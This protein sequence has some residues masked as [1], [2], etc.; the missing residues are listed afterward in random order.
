[1]NIPNNIFDEIIEYLTSRKTWLVLVHEK[2]DG[3]TL[4]SSAALVS[5]GIRLGKNVL[6]GGC[7]GVPA[8]Y[9]F[10]TA[11]L[12]YEV[13]PRTPFER[14]KK[15]ALIICVDTSTIDR[16]ADGLRDALAEYTVLNIDHHADNE[17]FGSL[18]WIDPTASAAGEMITELMAYSSWGIT[19][20]E[21][22]ALYTAIISDNGGFR[23]SS[24]SV[25]SHECAIELLRAGARPHEIAEE[26]DSSLTAGTLRLWGRAFS[27]AETFAD[28][29]A[30][31]FWLTKEDFKET[32]CSQAE[33][34][35]L[36][37]FL[38]RVKGTQL[39]ALVSGENDSARVSL[40]ARDPMNAQAVARLFGG[41]G[42]DL[43]AGCRVKGTVS[44]VLPGLRRT[45]E[46]HIE[47]RL[48]GNR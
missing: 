40:R 13:F 21:S 33:T 1:M 5:L 17:C 18:N 28:G 7:D 36:V 44:S 43:A 46:E 10:L 34:E 35:N 6:W 27:R 26:L 9:V 14:L 32:G 48:T 24:T 11:G 25:R 47:S 22:K 15:D 45:M 8:N 37:N 38:L 12:P 41:G 42:H 19:P 30:A 20:F 23:F 31:I 2:P 4:G 39:V 29:K 3:D 16:S